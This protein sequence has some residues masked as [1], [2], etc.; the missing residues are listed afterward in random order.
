MVFD[1][2]PLEEQKILESIMQSEPDLI[3]DKLYLGNL[4]HSKKHDVLKRL[5]VSVVLQISSEPT[6]FPFPESFE[7]HP[8]EFGDCPSADLARHV[9]K[10]IETLKKAHSEGK[11][12]FI[13]C[14]AG[15]SRSASIVIAYVMLLKDYDFNQALKFVQE[16]R[17]CVDPNEGFREYLA[18]LTF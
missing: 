13:H 4:S 12:C 5:G 15:V 16:R 14:A 18:K 9:K 7:Y 8:F 6:E 2:M 10:G 17:P 3:I 1:G 11:T